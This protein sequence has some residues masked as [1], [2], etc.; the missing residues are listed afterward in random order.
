MLCT[1][2]IPTC[3]RLTLPY[4]FAI[5]CRDQYLSNGD[6]TKLP[7]HLGDRLLMGRHVSDKRR[8]GSR[9]LRRARALQPTR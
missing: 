3:E 2:E 9:R 1:A 5:T 4:S 8:S 7:A 6:H